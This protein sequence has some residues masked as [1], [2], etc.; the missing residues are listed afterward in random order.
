MAQADA[1]SQEVA[2]ERLCRILYLLTPLN[3][4]LEEN[5]GSYLKLADELDEL[6]EAQSDDEYRRTLRAVEAKV[7]RGEEHLDVIA[8]FDCTRTKAVRAHR[9]AYTFLKEKCPGKLSGKA[10]II[11][12]HGSILW[13]AQSLSAGIVCAEAATQM[14]WLLKKFNDPRAGELAWALAP[15][16]KPY[17][18]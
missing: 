7:V 11:Q 18:K 8:F 14:M 5:D 6:I 10:P 4:L 2:T 16:A 15:F 12:S 9:E 1:V 17:T 13:P 3:K